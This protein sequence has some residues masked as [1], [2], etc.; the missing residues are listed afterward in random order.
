MEDLDSEEEMETEGGRQPPALEDRG[1]N[2]W[3][4]SPGEPDVPSSA[5]DDEFFSDEGRSDS[6][7][8]EEE[9]NVETPER[10]EESMSR[11]ITPDRKIDDPGEVLLDLARKLFL[12]EDASEGDPEIDFG[13]PTIE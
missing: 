6:S 10:G 13:G 7:D 12:A 11:D 1:E 5:S 9:L 2:V 3:R 8:G 4:E